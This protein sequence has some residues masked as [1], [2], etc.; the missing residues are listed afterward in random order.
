MTSTYIGRLCDVR[1]LPSSKNGNPRYSAIIVTDSG[2]ALNIRTGVDSSLAYSFTNYREGSR[3]N[4]T[5]SLQRGYWIIQS[6]EE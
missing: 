3:V 5:A 4:V 1:R 6:M 2:H